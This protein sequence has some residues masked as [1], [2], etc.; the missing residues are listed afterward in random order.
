[1]Q[2]GYPAVKAGEALAGGGIIMICLLPFV[3]VIVSRVDPRGLMAFGFISIFRG[4][5]YMSRQFNLT[6]DFRTAFM[7]RT[8]QMVGLASSSFLRMFWPM[9]AFLERRTIRFLP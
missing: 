8:Y 6:M 4:L 2:L 7:M 3:G 9:W 5:F 1:V